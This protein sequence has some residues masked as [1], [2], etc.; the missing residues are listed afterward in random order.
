M[1]VTAVQKQLLREFSILYAFNVALIALAQL[2]LY[3]DS[4]SAGTPLSQSGET[5]FRI[6]LFCSLLILKTHVSS[7]AG[8][9]PPHPARAGGPG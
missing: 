1:G 7:G 9:D 6:P 2:F 5:Q 4:C 3:Y 8:P